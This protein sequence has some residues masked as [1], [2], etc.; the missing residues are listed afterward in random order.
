[1]KPV[2]RLLTLLSLTTVVITVERVSP[3]TRV[4]MQ[5]YSYLHLH[6]V[7]QMGLISAFSVVVSFLLLR[8]VSRNFRLIEDPW[9]ALLALLFVL[10]TYFYATGNGVHEVASFLFNQYCDTKHFTSA[11]CGSM[12]FDDYYVGNIVYFLGL[13]LS[14]LALVLLE[15]RL[16]DRSYDPRDALTTVVNGCVLALTFF[17]YDAFDRVSV[18]LVSTIVYAIVF[19]LLLVRARIRY[20]FAPFTFYSALGFSLAAVV[21]TPV[22]LIA[23]I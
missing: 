5:P 18:G 4:L 23:G 8:A 19:D 22:R 7:V 10:G 17:A 12:Y 14:N 16:P 21:A 3:T 15:L 13:G 9:G 20:R 6:E 11:S 1:M 2:N